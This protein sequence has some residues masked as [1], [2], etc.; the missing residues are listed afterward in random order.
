MKTNSKCLGSVVL[1]TGL[2]AAA[3]CG[4][5]SV[6]ELEGKPKAVETKKVDVGPNVWL[7]VQGKERRVVIRGAVC[8]REG[9]LEVFLCRKGSK[10]H[11]SIVS[12][13]VDGRSIHEALNLAGAKEGSPVEFV[14]KYKAAHGDAIKVFIEYEEQ[15]RRK[16]V[17]ARDLIR[18]TKTKKELESDWVFA[19]SRLF[20]DPVEKDKPPIYLANTD[21]YFIGVSNFET[22]LLDVPISSPNDDAERLY[23][24]WTDRIPP[25]GTECTVILEPIN[26]PAKSP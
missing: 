14:P 9:A 21:G 2:L 5:S 15:G 13:D 24:A 22:A 7:E 18:Q 10:E 4:P 8:L 26:K 11:E 25:L 19:G 6:E 3:G 20:R 23:E 16:K 17:N 12:A 1:I